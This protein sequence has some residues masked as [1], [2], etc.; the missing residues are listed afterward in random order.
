[1]SYPLKTEFPIS[2]W[3][4]SSQSTETAPNS[5]NGSTNIGDMAEGLIMAL[6]LQ[7]P[8]VDELHVVF[9][10]NMSLIVSI[11]SIPC[12]CHM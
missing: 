9:T 5:L 7:K 4:G 12:K 3:H 6:N 11:I 1:M 2:N 8:S 10:F